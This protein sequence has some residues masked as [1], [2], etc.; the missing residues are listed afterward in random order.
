[1]NNPE[2]AAGSKTGEKLNEKIHFR[3]RAEINEENHSKKDQLQNLN[4]DLKTP[5]LNEFVFYNRMP[6]GN[7]EIIRARIHVFRSGFV[8]ALRFDRR[9][10]GAQQVH[11]GENVF[12]RAREQLAGEQRPDYRVSK[13]Q[14]A[15]QVFSDENALLAGFRRIQHLEAELH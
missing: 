12:R 10:R 14:A 7:L 5:K 9:A 11:F 3:S 1:M 6:R 15:R 2:A 8:D 13:R 4:P